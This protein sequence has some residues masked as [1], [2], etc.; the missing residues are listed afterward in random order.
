MREQAGEQQSGFSKER[1]ACWLLELVLQLVAHAGEA[2]LAVAAQQLARAPD[3]DGH[4]HGRRRRCHGVTAP[5]SLLRRLLVQCSIGIGH[6]PRFW[7]QVLQKA[8]A[9]GVSGAAIGV[10]TAVVSFLKACQTTISV[11]N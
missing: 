8:E 6:L 7:S 9:R 5:L 3:A 4:G 1:P 11:N 2:R 10:I